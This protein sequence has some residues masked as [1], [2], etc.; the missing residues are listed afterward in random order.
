MG[1]KNRWC[2]CLK[3]VLEMVPY[4]MSGIFP[5][6]DMIDPPCRKCGRE[7]KKGWRREV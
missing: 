1:F 6:Y 2:R 3:P 7:L 4:D 5:P